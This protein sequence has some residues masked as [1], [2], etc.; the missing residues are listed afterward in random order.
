MALKS[1]VIRAQFPSLNRREV[2]FDNPGGTQIAQPSLNRI[3]RYLLECNSNHEGAFATSRQ[4]DAVLEEARVAMADFLN[5]SSP[6]EIVFGN[7]MT[8]LTLHMS[9]ALARTLGPADEIVV[10]R[11]DHDANI[12]PVAADRRGPRLQGHLGGLRRRGRNA[13]GGRFRQGAGTPAQDRGVRLCLQRAGDDQ[14]GPQARCTWQRKPARSSTWTPCN[15]RPT[16]P[17]T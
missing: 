9:R 2:F 14:P 8:S 16:V 3:Q 4:S 5:A 7:N 17:S 6:R 11:L 13:A 12:S 15:M 10:T 1:D